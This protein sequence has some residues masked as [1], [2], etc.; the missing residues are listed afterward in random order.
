ME[1]NL[2]EALIDWERFWGA[3]GKTLEG[4]VVE[5]VPEE[6]GCETWWW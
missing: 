5:S 6:G 2:V 4:E 3:S 1:T